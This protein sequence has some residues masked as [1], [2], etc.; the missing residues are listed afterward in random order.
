M[1]KTEKEARRHE[2][3]KLVIVM[4]RK[5]I[6]NKEHNKYINYWAGMKMTSTV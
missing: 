4:G 3:Y 6:N 1:K 2:P 5:D